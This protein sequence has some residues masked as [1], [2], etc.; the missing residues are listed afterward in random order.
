MTSLHTTWT[1]KQV[2]MAAVEDG[3]T[4]F[5]ITYVCGDDRQYNVRGDRMISKP[6]CLLNTV[7]DKTRWFKTREGAE[8]FALHL[9]AESE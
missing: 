2:T 6:W 3:P 9:Q 1:P 5:V 8:F 4:L 7:T